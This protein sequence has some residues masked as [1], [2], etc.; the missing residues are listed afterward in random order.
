MSDQLFVRRDA[1]GRS[2]RRVTQGEGSGADFSPS[3][4][5]DDA[6]SLS[7]AS[8]FVDALSEQKTSWF[9]DM[10]K[11]EIRADRLRARGL[12]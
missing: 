8:Q 7:R 5:V 1:Q 10:A 11:A 2:A 4:A 9:D 12:L 6:G 3:L